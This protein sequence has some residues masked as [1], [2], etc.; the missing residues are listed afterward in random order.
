MQIYVSSTGVHTYILST[1][2]C[3]GADDEEEDEEERP[4]QLPYSDPERLDATQ[5]CMYV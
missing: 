4:S 2:S 5:V 3:L 1:D